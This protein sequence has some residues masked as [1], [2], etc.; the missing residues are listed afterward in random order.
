MSRELAGLAVAVLGA[1]AM[2]AAVAFQE[3]L[4][5]TIAWALYMTATLAWGSGLGLLLHEP[6]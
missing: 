1:F 5:A 6:T 3:S 4:S 2:G